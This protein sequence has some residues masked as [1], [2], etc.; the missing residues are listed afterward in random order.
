MLQQFNG[1][2]YGQTSTR[3]LRHDGFVIKKHWEAFSQRVCQDDF[4]RSKE[5]FPKLC[6]VLNQFNI[7]LE[8]E[9]VI[10]Q[11][12]NVEEFLH[13]MKEVCNHLFLREVFTHILFL[14]THH[15][16]W[17][18][19]CW[20]I[21]ALHEDVFKHF[22]LECNTVSGLIDDITTFIMENWLQWQDWILAELQQFAG[23]DRIEPENV[24]LE[25]DF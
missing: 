22:D 5:N 7:N 24:E 10:A 6:N 13:K 1:E 11:G 3:R 25:F 4:W 15:C 23:L 18:D 12:Q 9:L 8:Q 20:K 21:F 2:S 14:S 16:E 19:K 17:E